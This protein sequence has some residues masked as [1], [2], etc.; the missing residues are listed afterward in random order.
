MKKYLLAMIICYLLPSFL[1][2]Q[3]L[4][5]EQTPACPPICVPFT[6]SKIKNSP[7]EVSE[8]VFQLISFTKQ[9]HLYH[10]Y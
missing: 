4:S 1:N 10:A 3:V 7:E 9:C 6:A 2:A 5:V 8:P